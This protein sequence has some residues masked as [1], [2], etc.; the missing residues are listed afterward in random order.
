MLPSY[1]NLIMLTLTFSQMEFLEYCLHLM[2]DLPG[3]LSAVDTTFLLQALPKEMTTTTAKSRPVVCSQY[4]VQPP[5]FLLT[6]CVVGY[7]PNWGK[8]PRYID[9]DPVHSISA[10][11]FIT[12]KDT[13]HLD[14]CTCHLV[15]CHHYLHHR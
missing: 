14:Q 1:T 7:P 2:W 10:S 9:I 15:S 12:F 5:L 8:W 4:P 11:A 3:C 6:L 13:L